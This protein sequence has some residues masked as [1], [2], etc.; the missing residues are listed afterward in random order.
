[1]AFNMS[2]QNNPDIV[3]LSAIT[4]CR[5]E[6]DEQ[7]EEEEYTDQDGENKILCTAEVHIFL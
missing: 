7:R 4:S 2:E 1:M 5:M 3:P 6:I